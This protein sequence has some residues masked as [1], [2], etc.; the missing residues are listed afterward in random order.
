MSGFSQMQ[1]IAEGFSDFGDFKAIMYKTS[2]GR[3]F[4]RFKPLDEKEKA[5]VEWLSGD[6]YL[7]WLRLWGKSTAV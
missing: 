1:K 7:E 2:N 6:D 3:Y 4:V 5:Y